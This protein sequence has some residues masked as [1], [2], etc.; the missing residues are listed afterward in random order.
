MNKYKSKIGLGI[1][2][3][4]LAILG[5]TSAIMIINHIWIGLI[6]HFVVAGFIIYMFLT[7]YYLISGNDLTIKCGFMYNKTIKIENIKKITETNNPLSS[8][9]TSLDRIA[10]FYNKFDSIM[11][12]PKDKADFIYQ[13]KQINDKIEVI[14]K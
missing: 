8:P 13:L 6:V 1:V 14:T 9:A 7:T 10:I 11:I 5:T 3:F 2:L 12:S 4:I